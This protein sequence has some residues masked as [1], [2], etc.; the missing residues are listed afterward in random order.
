MT[1]EST[2]AHVNVKQRTEKRKDREGDGSVNQEKKKRGRP[3]GSIG[4]SKKTEGQFLGGIMKSEVS[5]INMTKKPS[6][7]PHSTRQSTGGK[8]PRYRTGSESQRRLSQGLDSRIRSVTR[9]YGAGISLSSLSAMSMGTNARTASSISPHTLTNAGNKRTVPA[10][11]ASSALTTG[12]RRNFTPTTSRKDG[13]NSSSN[14]YRKNYN[15][16]N[17]SGHSSYDDGRLSKDRDSGSGA[18]SRSTS[19]EA[20]T[21]NLETVFV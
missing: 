17:R 15:D 1:G 19:T 11:T 8:E 20:Q 7:S 21:S 6:S 3:R 5:N 14:I 18:F 2:L 16:R 10:A 9:G 4:L 13:G 12:D